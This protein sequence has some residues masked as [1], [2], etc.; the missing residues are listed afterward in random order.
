[1]NKESRQ[2]AQFLGGMPCG[3]TVLETADLREFLLTTGGSMMAN[4]R[5]YN[6][7]SEHLGAG[8]HRVTLELMHP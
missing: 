7:K 5:L 4:G 1:M 6:I 2:A 3:N 8:V